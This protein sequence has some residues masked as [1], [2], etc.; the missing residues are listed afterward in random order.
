M[1]VSNHLPTHNKQCVQSAAAIAAFTI[2]V[3]VKKKVFPI[4]IKIKK[5]ETNLNVVT[6][7]VEYGFVKERK[8]R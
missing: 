8:K 1:R 5:N 7:L 4:Q 2:A 6:K 3:T